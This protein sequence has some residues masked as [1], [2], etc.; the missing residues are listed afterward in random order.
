MAIP[1]E[2]RDAEK[3]VRTYCEQRIPPHI[4]DQIRL[5]T[6]TRGRTVTI[7]ERRP[8]WR[9]D[10]GPEWS[11]SKV[12]QLRYETGAGTWTLHWSD[13]NGRWHL[14]NLVEPSPDVE[15]LLEEIDRDPTGI[16]WG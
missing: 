5:E 2:V 13:R 3:L 15:P 9:P 10:W 8:P 7:L 1:A 12:A 6:A 16:F 4:R 14:Y 11:S